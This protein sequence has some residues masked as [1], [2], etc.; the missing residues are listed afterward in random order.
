MHI[1]KT[2]GLFMGRAKVN[3]S[4]CFRSGKRFI[5][6]SCGRQCGVRVCACT[7]VCRNLTMC[8]HVCDCVHTC[9]D[10]HMHMCRG[11]G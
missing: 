1:H 8:V 5:V 2:S 6:V 4:G 11:A 7:C 10:M 9:V 3:L